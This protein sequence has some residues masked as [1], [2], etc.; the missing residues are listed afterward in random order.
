MD[1]PVKLGDSISNGA[2]IHGSE[3]VGGSIFYRFLI[4]SCQSDVVCDV[5]SGRTDQGVGM[6]VCA[7]PFTVMHRLYFID[8]T[9]AMYA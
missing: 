8:V 5:I 4:D 1:V 6:G 9:Y 3:V 7:I 2:Q